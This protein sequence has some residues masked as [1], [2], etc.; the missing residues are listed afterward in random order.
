MSASKFYH[1]NKDM[2]KFLVR[3]LECIKIFISL[4]QK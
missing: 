3:I 4:I 2:I 1:Y